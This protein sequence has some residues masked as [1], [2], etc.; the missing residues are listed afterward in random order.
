MIVFGLFCDDAALFAADVGAVPAAS[1]VPVC[2]ITLQGERDHC[3]CVSR[4]VSAFVNNVIFVQ[5]SPNDLQLMSDAPAHMLFVLLGPV[6]PTSTELPD[7]LCAIQVN[8][9]S[10]TAVSVF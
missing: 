2:V 5:N 6:S 3:C 9:L 7:I 4:A 8:A 1:H 10:L